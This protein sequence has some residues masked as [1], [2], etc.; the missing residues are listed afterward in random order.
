MTSTL[1]DLVLWRFATLYPGVHFLSTDFYHVHLASVSRQRGSRSPTDYAIHDIRGQRIDY[2]DDSKP[3]VFMVN[4]GLIHWNLFRVQFKPQ[5]QLQLFE[6]MGRLS[7][8]TGISM[9]SVPR[10]VL[11]WLGT[12]YPAHGDWLSR[13]VSAITRTQQLSGFDCGVACLLYAEKCGQ[14]RRPEDINELIEQA[15]ITRYRSRLQRKL[16]TMPNTV[17]VASKHIYSD[18][19]IPS[20]LSTRLDTGFSLSPDPPRR[21]GTQQTSTNNQTDATAGRSGQVPGAAAESG[22]KDMGAGANGNNCASSSFSM[23]LKSELLGIDSPSRRPEYTNYMDYYSNQYSPDSSSML[24][25]YGGSFFTPSSAGNNGTGG[26]LTSRTTSGSANILRFKAPRQS[27][28]DDIKTSISFSGIGCSTQRMLSSDLLSSRRKIAKTPFKILDAPALQD[29]FYLN[30]V[31]WSSSNVLAVGLGASVYLW[32]ACTSKV[33]KLCDLGPTDCVTSVAWSQRGTHLSVGTNSGEVQIWEATTCKLVRTMNGHVARVGTLA[34]SSQLIAS[35]SRDRNI[36]LRD[37]RTPE[38]FQ[39]KLAGHKQEVCGL[40]WSF[41]DH[42][43]AS[44]G[45]DNKLFVWNVNTSSSSLANAQATA[46]APAT[47]P[48]VRF[49][50]HTA[51]VKAIAWSPHQHGLLASGGGT[52]DRCIRFWNTHTQ[53]H[54]NAIDTGSQVCNLMWSKNVNEVVSTHGYSLNQIIVWK[55]PTMTKLATLT[56]HTFRVLYL[57]M[58]PDGQTIVTGAGD[59]TLRFWNAFPSCKSKSGSRLGTNLLFPLGTGSEIR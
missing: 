32:S 20:R 23:L 22:V 30:L 40:K 1:M 11:E 13:T 58:S 36:Y 34:W 53:T 7:S 27:I 37:I 25:G 48:M 17:S 8:R 26:I 51:A 50:E 6:P 12:C 55:Y 38:P 52:A 43:L 59:E 33:T 5:P 54:L 4:T 41:D 14:D 57:A 18:R 56:G 31:D 47:I 3:I 42:Q 2:C 35:G 28:H 19:F 44:G 10:G 21:T 46:H 39:H 15:D 45:N 49:S 16:R 9:R 29:D 24:P